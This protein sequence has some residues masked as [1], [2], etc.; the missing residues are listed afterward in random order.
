MRYR[1]VLITGAGGLLGGY[2]AR[3]LAPH[4]AVSGFDVKTPAEPMPFTQGDLT[5]TGAVRRAVAGADAIVHVGAISNVRLGTPERIMQV[6]VQGTWNLL[7]AAEEAGVRRVVLCS[8]DSVLGFTVLEGKMIPPARLPVMVDDPLAPTD[9]YAL[10]KLLGEGIGKSF[11]DRGMEIVALRPV[12]ILF[13][14]QEGEVIARARDP[15]G[16]RWPAAGGHAPAGGGPMWH[17]VDPRDVAEA[18]RLALLLNDVRFEAFWV[19]GPNTLAPEPTLERF[20]RRAGRAPTVTRPEV[21]RD[22]PY[23]PLYDLEHARRR[24]GFAAAHDRRDLLAGI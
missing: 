7:A 2:L 20:A 3:A 19:S 5:D 8:S 10:S 24:L 16:Y 4:T 9:P 14:S 1:K 21:Y 22:S 11:A 18:F 17:Y 6:N 23:A 15:Q 13:P 12:F